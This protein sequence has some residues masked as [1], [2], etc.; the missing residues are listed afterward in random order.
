MGAWGYGPWEN[1]YSRDWY[2]NLSKFL[3]NEL[4]K[5]SRN[6]SFNE[7]LDIVEIVLKTAGGCEDEK[8]WL[9][10]L[11]SLN[12]ALQ[13]NDEGESWADEWDAPEKIKSRIRCQKR[14][15]KTLL[16]KNG[17]EAQTKETL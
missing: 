8:L 1:D 7:V 10:A 5:E 3:K 14:R 15:L 16:E 17:Y 12:L 2:Y 13:K 11:K 6:S 4:T 9:V